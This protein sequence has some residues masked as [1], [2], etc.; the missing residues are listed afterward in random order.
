V[1]ETTQ[2]TTINSIFIIKQN[3]MIDSLNVISNQILQQKVDSLQF[4]LLIM[5]NKEDFFHS[6]IEHQQSLFT[7]QTA[8]FSLIVTIVLFLSGLIAWKTI[9]QRTERKVTALDK[10]FKQFTQNLKIGEIQEQIIDIKNKAEESFMLATSGYSHACRALYEQK[11]S[12]HLD[13]KIIWHIRY[14]NT[15]S[16]SNLSALKTRMSILNSEFT[17]LKQNRAKFN[18]LKTFENLGGLKTILKKYST[19]S[20]GEINGIADSILNALDSKSEI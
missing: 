18:S 9:I 19:T 17:T 10:D 5:Q 12:S 3:T 1:K 20:D 15:F 14:I 11:D 13:W 8:I 4:Q 2:L 7:I 6:V 16:E